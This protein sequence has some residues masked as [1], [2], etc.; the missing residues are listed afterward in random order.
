MNKN[1]SCIMISLLFSL[2]CANA[3]II[4]EG[5]QIKYGNTSFNVTYN[6]TTNISFN[7]NFSVHSRGIII[8][9]DDYVNITLP[10]S[11]LTLDVRFWNLTTG[12]NRFNL[13]NSQSDILY[14]NITV[15]GSIGQGYLNSS[16]VST[17]FTTYSIGLW[18]YNATNISI[19]DCI[20]TW[21]CAE[22]TDKEYGTINCLSGELTRVCTDANSC[23]TTANKPSE[24][25]SCDAGSGGGSSSTPIY[26]LLGDDLINESNVS[27]QKVGGSGV[28]GELSR[29]RK[30]AIFIIAILFILSCIALIFFTKKKEGIRR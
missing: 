29:T 21:S 17:G 22:W 7:N 3:L 26:G 1:I 12:F 4:G 11:S 27:K 15:N 18:F 25:M 30:T 20:E 10:N 6:F 8:D 28:F 24:S 19:G 5:V 13:T 9:G 14:Y 23:G 2:V 16:N